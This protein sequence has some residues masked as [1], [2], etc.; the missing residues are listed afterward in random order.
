MKLEAL[1]NNPER[2][3]LGPVPLGLRFA[4]VVMRLD[5]C[6]VRRSPTETETL[7]VEGK[8][9]SCYLLEQVSKESRWQDQWSY[10]PSVK[11]RRN[12]ELAPRF[13]NSTTR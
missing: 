5:I 13:F 4:L 3:G 11:S 1:A 12:G 8:V 10:T 2:Q 6:N 7:R 9:E